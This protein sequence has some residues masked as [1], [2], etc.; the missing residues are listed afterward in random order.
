MNKTMKRI[1]MWLLKK[2]VKHLD[3]LTPNNTLMNISWGKDEVTSY[4]LIVE[5]CYPDKHLYGVSEDYY[6]KNKSA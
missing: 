2:S 3:K 4:H 5:R 6:D 1:W